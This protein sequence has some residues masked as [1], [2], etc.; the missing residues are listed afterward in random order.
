MAE[1]RSKHLMSPAV[2]APQKAFF[3]C[4]GTLLHGC[5]SGLAPFPLLVAAQPYLGLILALPSRA[6]IHPPG[7]SWSLKGAPALEAL[8]ILLVGPAPQVLI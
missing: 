8:A 1:Y 3:I 2:L 6:T 4:Y 7:R 5:V